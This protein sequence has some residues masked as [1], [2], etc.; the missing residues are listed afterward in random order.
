MC[1]DTGDKAAGW[2]VGGKDG[3]AEQGGRSVVSRFLCPWLSAVW[4][5]TGRIPGVPP[6]C[7][8]LGL[9]GVGVGGT[10]E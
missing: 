4:E 3:L 2:E 5:E 6:D 1:V 7:R 9:A 10:L 8:G